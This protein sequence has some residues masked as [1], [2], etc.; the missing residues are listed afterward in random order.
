MSVTMDD[1]IKRWTAK[2]NRPAVADLAATLA[3]CNRDEIVALQTS[4][5]MN[6]ISCMWPIPHS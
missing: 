1:S 5:P 4:S 3:A 6:V 2:R